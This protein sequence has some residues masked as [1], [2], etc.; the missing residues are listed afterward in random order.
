MTSASNLPP[1]A[2]N[3]PVL[4]KGDRGANVRELQTLLYDYGAF[5]LACI[6]GLPEALIDG[7]FGNDT[8]DTV[9]AFQ[10]QVFLT[11]DGIVGNITW[12]ALIRKA[13]INM[14]VLRRGSKGELVS[15]VQIRLIISGDYQ[16]AIDGDFGIATEEAVKSLQR[17]NR[18]DVDGI[19]GNGTW[20]LLSQI[21]EAECLP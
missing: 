20:L 4:K 15:R 17:R 8:E 3:R 7:D 16:G 6:F 18:S 19:I 14:P 21:K 5:A 10:R 11:V 9:K 1:V 12:Q 13:P 2:T